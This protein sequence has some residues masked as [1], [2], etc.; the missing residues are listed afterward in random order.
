MKVS[1]ITVSF[2]S[3]STIE[4][5]IRSV[6]AQTHPDI[7]YIIV[8]GNSADDTLSI[9]KKYKDKITTLVSEKDKGIYYALNKGIDLATGHVIGTLHSDDVYASSE[10]IS[11]VVKC[12]KEKKVDTV[13]GDLQYV[14]RDDLNK[15][16]RYWQAE[17]YTDGLFLKGWMPPHP[18]FF[19]KKE[20]YEKYGKFNTLLK[21]SADYELMLRFLHKYKVSTA[22][23]P[24]VIVKMRSGGQSNLS[25]SNRIKA[26][27]ED[28]LAWKLN[29]LT[30]GLFTTIAKPLSKLGQFLIR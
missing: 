28:R 5:T 7:E 25:I 18:T 4:D 24:E 15:V 13:Y 3:A 8:D 20:C 23:I 19:V 27:K 1:I 12:F 14:N 17:Q 10:I 9:I 26:N 29:G 22:Y 2:N 6:S 16:K 30:P 11:N 21:S